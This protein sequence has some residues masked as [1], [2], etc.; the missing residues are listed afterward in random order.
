MKPGTDRLAVLSK[1]RRTVGDSSDQG[2]VKETLVFC[3]E[4]GERL[5]DARFWQIRYAHEGHTHDRAFIFSSSCKTR[6]SRVP[7]RVCISGPRRS[8]LVIRAARFVV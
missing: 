4:D 8:R 3:I 7:V 5:P 1:I 6:S 2:T